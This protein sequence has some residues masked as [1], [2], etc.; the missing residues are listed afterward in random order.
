MTRITYSH[1]ISQ[2]REFTKNNEDLIN[3]KLVIF[4]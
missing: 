3:G 1:T 4:S 2:V